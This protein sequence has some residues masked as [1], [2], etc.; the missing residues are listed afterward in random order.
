VTGTL[1]LGADEPFDLACTLSC[2]QLFRWEQGEGWWRG[3]VRGRLV[4]VRQQE[5]LLE[6][7]GCDAASL[8]NYFQLDLD[9][10]AVLASVNR[11]PVIGTAIR[12]HRGLRLVRQE[13][14]ECLISYICAQNANIPFIT[15]M[16]ANLAHAFGD[17]IPGPSGAAVHAFPAPGELAAASEQDLAGCTLGYRATYV[18][19]TA[20]AV[21]SD[22]GWED[23]IRGL[24][25]GAARARLMT[26]RGV[27]PK[28]ADCVLL[29]AF[30]RFEA[31]PV[32][33]RIRK[34]MYRHYLPDACRA[35]PLS[36]R[37]YETISRFS[38]EYFGPYAGYAQEYLYAEYPGQAAEKK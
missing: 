15:R 24:D 37:E 26:Y 29:F 7:D 17:P 1:R 22:P 35:N 38:R 6:F 4:R 8:R 21:A 5:D 20:R 18:L 33:V 25:Y 3:V 31:F 27:G 14:W 9:L 36:C 34:V 2:G 30:D 23:A 13:P 16:I 11:D 19:D 12:H 32:D 10:D 28:V